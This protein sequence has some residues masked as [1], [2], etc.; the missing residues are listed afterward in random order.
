MKHFTPDELERTIDLYEHVEANRWEV[1][2]MREDDK[3][4]HCE[5]WAFKAR[6]ILEERHLSPAD[7]AACTWVLGVTLAIATQ[8]GIYVH[9]LSRDHSEDWAGR[10]R[11]AAQRIRAR[12][13]RVETVPVPRPEARKTEAP[14][15]ERAPHLPGLVGANIVVV[16]GEP[17]TAVLERL[18]GAEFTL[19]WTPT[20]IRQVQSLVER[21][22]VGKVDGVI[23]L[24]DANRHLNFFLVRDA[25]RLSS[26]PLTLA[27]R[28]LAAM[29]RA[30]EQLN[31]QITRVP[32]SA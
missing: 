2:K 18:R 24:A 30:L 31:E 9:G 28:G 12:Q 19:D 22:K 13:M 7:E 11:L 20:N 25:C 15:P 27:T 5:F 29:R 17:D 1:P 3:R 14:T 6:A 32:K 16:G 21:I 4:L 8:A 23:F 10:A 26:T